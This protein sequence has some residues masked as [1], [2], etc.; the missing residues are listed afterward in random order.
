V[1]GQITNV[2]GLVLTLNLGVAGANGAMA[3][4][5]VGD[6]IVQRG[7]S[8]ES[9]RQALIYT[10]V[11]DAD[12]PFKRTMTGIDSLAAFNDLDNVVW[13]DGDLT[14][15]ASHDIVPAAPGYGLYSTN[16]YLSGTIVSGGDEHK[17]DDWSTTGITLAADGSIHTPNFYV[18]VGGEIGLRQV[19]SVLFKIDGENRGIKMSGSNIWENEIDNDDAGIL[20]INWQGYDGG[21]TRYRDFGIGNGKNALMMYFLG[22]TDMVSVYS[23]IVLEKGRIP[24]GH[25]HGGTV[26][27][28]EIFDALAPAIPD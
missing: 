26:T 14:S 2:A 9:E 12:A 10:T 8:T 25:L 16:A 20:K 1:R 24:A 18:N 3:D 13:Q 7:N 17:T 23:T 19:E 11:S 5:A 28:N 15:L 4:I 27:Y 21:A 22:S 6:V